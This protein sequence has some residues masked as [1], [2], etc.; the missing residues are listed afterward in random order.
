MAANGNDAIN[1]GFT[2]N[3]GTGVF[4]VHDAE[5]VALSASNPGFVRF[6]DKATPGQ[7]LY[8]SVEAN[9]AFIDDVGASEIINNLF[10]TT[11]GVAWGVD[12]PFYLYGVVSDDKASVAMMISRVPH[13]KA[14]PVVGLIGAPDD[15][16]ADNEFSFF[17]LDNID[18]TLYDGNPCTV[19]GSFVMQ[20]SSSDDW[21]VQA[22]TTAHGVGQFQDN[23][24]FAWPAGVNGA[25]SGTYM[26]ANGGT[27]PDFTTEVAAYTLTKDGRCEVTIFLNGDGG[28]DGA[29]AVVSLVSMP[30]AIET[31]NGFATHVQPMGSG[32]VNS[33]TGGSHGVTMYSDTDNS[34][35]AVILFEGEN[36]ASVQNLD[37]TNG[38]RQLILTGSY[39]A[40]R[41][42]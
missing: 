34:L 35:Q 26:L 42:A 33:A 38:A 5:G 9:Q 39:L 17:S 28:T 22:L 11:T 27:A 24:S 6:Q 19:L 1:L 13:L 18:E 31:Q 15:A 36:A 30:M 12:C 29:G 8:V 16:V 40:R 10:G 25:A 21:T 14:A 41:S 7:S 23:V 20:M 2:Y 4:T 37:F 32:T 3:G